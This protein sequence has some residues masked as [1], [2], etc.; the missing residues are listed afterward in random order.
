MPVQFLHE[1]L[2]MLHHVGFKGIMYMTIQVIPPVKMVFEAGNWIVTQDNFAPVILNLKVLGNFD[3]L[4][5]K[6]PVIATVVVPFNQE[7]LTVQ[8]LQNR[9]CKIEIAPEHI[10]KNI[11]DVSR[12][13]DAIPTLDERLIH[14]LNRPERAVI[15][16]DD[17]AMPIAPV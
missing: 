6:S 4:L 1:V 3:E 2:G 13:H 15:E 5:R 8:L 9:N 11:D 12:L 10:A 16:G 17:V 14:L 7:L